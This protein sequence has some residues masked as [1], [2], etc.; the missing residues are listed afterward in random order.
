MLLAAD[1]EY[2]LLRRSSQSGAGHDQQRGDESESGQHYYYSDEY[3]VLSGSQS[4]LGGNAIGEMPALH[5]RRSGYLGVKLN[6][7]ELM[8]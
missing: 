4:D 7:A 3:G 6:E 1:D 8:Q 5:V 2:R